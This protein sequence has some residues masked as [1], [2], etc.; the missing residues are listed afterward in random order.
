MGDVVDLKHTIA[1]QVSRF[2]H[3][4]KVIYR[5]EVSPTII[6]PQATLFVDRAPVGVLALS[7]V[8]ND[9]TVIV[10]ELAR[11]DQ[12]LV[13]ADM[14]GLP[15]T[16]DRVDQVFLVEAENYILGLLAEELERALGQLSWP[17][18]GAAVPDPRHLNPYE[19][20]DRVV[21]SWHNAG[22]AVELLSDMVAIE[23]FDALE[24]MGHALADALDDSDEPCGY[25]V[26]DLVR[27]TLTAWREGDDDDSG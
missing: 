21:T 9:R 25:L 3:V 2:G 11:Q 5:I 8:S 19:R 15:T 7:I 17:S 16:E 12:E 26:R 23:V 27:T 4:F 24:A 22:K 20:G 10:L 18:E 6:E 14:L 13:T 1:A